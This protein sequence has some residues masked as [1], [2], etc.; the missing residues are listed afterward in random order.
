MNTSELGN[1]SEN[2]PDLSTNTF[3]YLRIHFNVF[4]VLIIHTFKSNRDT[5]FNNLTFLELRIIFQYS[6]AFKMQHCH[7]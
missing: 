6:I 7:I 5:L 3:N 1:Y 2:L 4:H